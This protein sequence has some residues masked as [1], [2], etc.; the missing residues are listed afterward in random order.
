MSKERLGI[1]F[2]GSGFVSQFHIR[3]LVSVRDADVAG[4]VSPTR[5]HA[6]AAAALARQLGVGSPK[7][8]PSIAEMA[9]DPA[10]DALWIC[11]PNDTRIA[12][13]E[14]IVDAVERGA[15]LIGVACEKPLARTVAEAR[16]MLELV[17]RA[18][19]LHGYLENQ[20][21]APA[22]ARGKEIIW[23]R[24][25]GI[26]GRPYLARAAEEHS[27]PHMPWFW[28]GSRQGGGVLNDMLCHSYE[29]ARFLLTAPGEPRDALTVS[30][31][32]A[33]IASLKWTR[34]EYAVMLREQTGGAVDYARAPAEDFARATV[35]LRTPEGFPAL[36]EATTSWS[37]V[38]PGLRLR[39]EVLGPEYSM[40]VD[41]LNSE[42]SVF[43][44]RRVTG[45][46][47]EDLVEKQNA[48]QG[49]MPVVPDEEAS[50]G[51]AAEN[52]HMVRAFLES[53]QPQET[54]EDGLAVT[55]VLMA[56]Y[57]SA[58]RGQVVRFPAPELET[59]VPAVAQGTWRP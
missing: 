19:L 43:L 24:A 9:A 39:M 12:V 36:V 41:T 31:V 57:L 30:D 55:A 49:L 50:Y 51:Y 17:Q 6:E 29:A 26:T 46:G 58:E 11:S 14:E 25:A 32:N 53:Q 3:S 20:V 33:Q 56:C 44:S 59:F 22:L 13:V 48:E 35:R 1:G 23:R 27:G 37:F 52:R 10:V 34:K 54:W 42:L 45:P 4:V 16:R 38:G 47:G 7:V 15:S 2:V 40:Q 21:F 5:E 28:L 18:R 8:F